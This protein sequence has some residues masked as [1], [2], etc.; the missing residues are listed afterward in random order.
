MD[1]KNKKVLMIGMGISGNASLRLLIAKGAICDVYDGKETPKIDESIKDK[2]RRYY[3]GGEK[4]NFLN[5]DYDLVVASP[6]VPTKKGIIKEAK[7][8]FLNVIGEVE[9]AYS[10]A[11]GKFIA[12][13]GTNGKTTTTTWVYDVFKRAG[14]KAHLAGNVGIPLSDVVLNFDDE[15]DIYICELSSY[16]LESID[17]FKPIISAILNVTPDHLARHG[18]MEEY[19]N[20]KYNIAKNM[21]ENSKLILNIDDNILLNYYNNSAKNLN[22]EL[23]CFSK[24]NK[25]SDI[26]AIDY[27]IKMGLK[28]EHNLENALAVLAICKTYGI[29]EDIIFDSLLNFKGVEHRNEFVT[30]INGVSYYNDSKATNPEAAIPALKSLDMPVYLIAGGMDKGNDY[31]AWI[32]NFKNVKMVFLFGE[33]KNDIANAMKVKGLNKFEIFDNLDEAFNAATSM[34]RVGD[35]ILLSPACASWDMY[36][37]FE[38][39][40][41]HFKRLV[42]GLK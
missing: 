36:E 18:T 20:A 22:C 4:P 38:K 19:A 8:N 17:S 32:D 27:D 5:C 11:K 14:L 10:F 25:D 34:A 42:D 29:D 24:Y 3:L 1:L 23:M 16:Q 41:E 13:T 31:D 33:T 21:D 15:D 26:N 2:V 40:G 12:I 37:S 28:G 9:L 39:R 30:D 35:A 6:G 7:D